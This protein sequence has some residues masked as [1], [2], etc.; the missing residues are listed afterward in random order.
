L[1]LYFASDAPGDGGWEFKDF[2]RDLH[3]GSVRSQAGP[4]SG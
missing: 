2:P 3:L 1:Q 4:F